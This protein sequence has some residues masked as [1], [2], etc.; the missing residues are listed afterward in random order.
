MLLV[1]DVKDVNKDIRI[2]MLSDDDFSEVSVFY[3]FNAL[4]LMI[5]PL[6]MGPLTL[7][8]QTRKS[9]G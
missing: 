8:N 7:L 1:S 6:I 3:S 5:S 2:C 9:E 4:E